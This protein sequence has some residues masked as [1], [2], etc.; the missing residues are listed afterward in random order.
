MPDAIPVAEI[1]TPQ[2]A[3]P[4]GRKFPCPS[5]GARLDFDPSVRGLKCPYCGH[6]Q[7]IEKGHAGDV[8]EREIDDYLGREEA[9]GKAIPGRET[10]TRCPGCGAVVLLEEKVA[11]ERC[12][13]CAT[14]L[15]N[16]PESAAGMIAPESLLPFEVEL[17]AARD[18]FTAWLHSLWFAP[19]EL[20]TAARLGQ[21]TGVYLPY[22]TY[23]AQTVTFYD[24]ERG[25]NYTVTETY[26]TRNAQG[27]TVTETR[28]VVHTRWYPVSGDVA[29]F[30]DDVLVP[31][32]HSVPEDLLA[33]AAPW[34]L[35]KL[36][37]FRPDY[38]SGFRA[39]RYA[40]GLKEGLT[41]AKRVMQPTIDRL[42]RQDIGGD[43]QRVHAQKTRYSA[44]TFKP[45]L[46]PFW[47]AVYRYQDKT[48][49][50]LVNGHNGKVTGYRPYSWMKIVRFILLILL[51]VGGIV[52]L[53]MWL[54]NR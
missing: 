16:K 47:V 46:L 13:F 5:C 20:R 44:V 28:N 4:A 24:G 25:D 51:A 14:A 41:N 26:T 37:P 49:Q 40:V 6:Q 35:N 32:S 18:G 39:E 2:P 8:L 10:Q 33:D 43:H 31:A 11:T 45:L 36:E 50:V 9:H 12:P 48:Y 52:A 15:E 22:W 21:L 23:D 19:G 3:P 7:K 30:F 42:V 27:E 34:P 17:R 1:V 53:V 29:H 54:S 38:L